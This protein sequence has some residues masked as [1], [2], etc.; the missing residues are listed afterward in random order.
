MIFRRVGIGV[1]RQ[2]NANAGLLV[3]LFG[4]GHGTIGVEDAGAGLSGTQLW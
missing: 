3:V 1:V 4:C 2:R